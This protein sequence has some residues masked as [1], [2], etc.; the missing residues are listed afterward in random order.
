MSCNRSTKPLIQEILGNDHV[1]DETE[2]VAI[3]R[4]L[5]EVQLFSAN[6]SMRKARELAD[7]VSN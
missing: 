2:E 6:G 4:I 5:E 3:Y 1:T 7:S